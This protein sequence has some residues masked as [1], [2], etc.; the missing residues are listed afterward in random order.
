MKRFVHILLLFLIW[1]F[2]VF[3]QVQ[4]RCDEVLHWNPVSLVNGQKILSF[5]GSAMMD[6]SYLPFFQK[7]IELKNEEIVDSVW[8]TEVVSKVCSGKEIELLKDLDLQTQCRLSVEYQK[9][10]KQKKVLLIVSPFF[11]TEEGQIRKLL[12]F[13]LNYKV[14]SKLSFRSSEKLHFFAEESKLKSGKWVKLA[15]Q[16]SGVYKI[17]FE[18]LQSWGIDNPA[19]AR[20]FGYGGAMLNE[21]F[22][23]PKKDDL[24]QVPVWIEK[25][26]DEIFNAGDFILFYAQGPVSW[27]H[28]NASFSHVQNPYSNVGYYFVSSDA[29]E[30]LYINDRLGDDLEPTIEEPITTFVDFS[31][32]ENDLVSLTSKGREFYGEQISFGTTEDFDF[33]FPNRNATFPIN[34]RVVSAAKVSNYSSVLSVNVNNVLVGTK[35]VYPVSSNAFAKEIDAT[36]EKIVASNDEITVGLKNLSSTA[37]LWLNYIEVS[38]MRNLI[39]DGSQMAFSCPQSVANEEVC[40]FVL[41]EADENIQVWNITDPNQ[42][43]L[44][45]TSFDENKSQLTFVDEVSELQ[46]YIAVNPTGRF[47]SPSFVELVENQN[48]HGEKDVQLVIVSHEDF[49]SQANE[50]ARLHEQYDGIKTLVVTPKQIFN[51]Y[52]SGTP[53]ATAFRWLMKQFYDRVEQGGKNPENLLLFGATTCDHRSLLSQN[54]QQQKMLSYQSENSLSVDISSYGTDDYFALLDDEEGAN[55][56]SGK[57]DIGVGRLWARTTDEANVLVSKIKKYIVDNQKGSWKTNLIYLAD[58][59]PDQTNGFDLGFTYEGDFLAKQIESAYP[60]F[61]PRRMFFDAYPQVSSASSE[62]L[63]LLREKL[64]QQINKGVLFVDYTGHGSTE[65]IGNERVLSRSD[66][67]S[68]NNS[69]LP[70]FF[71]ATCDFAEYDQLTSSIGKELHLKEN[72]GAIALITSNRSVYM[73]GNFSLNKAFN[74]LIL[75]RE[76]GKSLTLGEINRRAKNQLSDK[77]QLSYCLLGDPALRVPLPQNVVSVDTMKRVQYLDYKKYVCEEGDR[78]TLKALSL[79]KIKGKILAENHDHLSDFNGF[80]DVVLWDKK[81]EQTTFG[82]T[83]PSQTYTYED[84]INVLFSGTT[85]VK[86]G[87]YELLVKIPKDIN[88]SLGEGRLT[89]Y[90]Y[91]ENQNRDALGYEE[92][93]LVGSIENDVVMETSGPILS[94]YLNSEDFYSGKNVDS[95]PMLFA[96]F[97]DVSGINVSG[98]GAGHDLVMTIAGDTTFSKVLNDY[99]VL[100]VN[101]YTSGRLQYQ[102]PK[103]SPGNYTLTLC[104]FDILNNSTSQTIAFS[105]G[106][107]NR[108]EIFNVVPTP[109]PASPND[110]FAFVIEHNADGIQLDC[111]LEVFDASGKKYFQTESSFITESKKSELTWNLRLSSGSAIPSGFYPYR[112]R[113]RTGAGDEEYKTGTLIVR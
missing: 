98:S 19:Q 55:L 91:E 71:T 17:T 86:N 81:V 48:L 6:D 36:F 76:N 79:V 80:V 70:I 68:M 3:S 44:L 40:R 67:S 34:I 28:K 69:I 4:N 30:D 56:L 20:V 33:Y 96:S 31:V 23:L 51:E 24:P 73:A 57:M 66:I 12:S 27:K 5:V 11:K 74:S 62:T 7:M 88:Y 77:N 94:M 100:D 32:Y 45:P 42:T 87:A 21:D 102:L 58:D 9:E 83:N 13:S 54:N 78:D 25:G 85:I 37:Q 43:I 82:N 111:I 52:S 18:Q 101:S 22:S 109:N 84:R 92:Q 2:A 41:A 29:G 16:E 26:V 59:N 49:L 39:M 46:Q 53:D 105:I 90:A 89:L 50:V 10:Q 75:K 47:P 103:M 112:I 72:G 99:F 110:P 60:E 113:F 108:V 95:E 35:A 107:S 61:T 14:D 97:S 106:E 104:V 8:L 38:A 1:S 15:V 64:F 65:G 63:P 93:F